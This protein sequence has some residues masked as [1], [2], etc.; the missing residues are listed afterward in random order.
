MKV[1]IFIVLSFFLLMNV[2]ANAQKKFNTKGEAQLRIEDTWSKVVAKNKVRQLAKINAIERVFGTYIEQETNIDI[3]DGEI[4]F[5]ILGNTRVKGEWLKTKDESFREDI[6]EVKSK[7]GKANEIWITCKIN[8]VVREIVRPKLAFVTNALNCQQAECRT[9]RFINGE[10]FYLHFKS[11][12]S[13]FLSVYIVEDDV[14]YRMLPY[15]EMI[16][17]YI[18]AVPVT[19]DKEYIFF[20][21]SEKHDYFEDFHFSRIDEI[22]METEDDKEYLKLYVVFS[23][24]K[25]SKPILKEGTVIIDGPIPK[26]LSAL[27]FEQWISQNRIYN[28]D[29]NY[30]ILNLEIVKQ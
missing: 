12:S 19:H 1:K 16:T 25:F 14:V 24:K 27:K 30:E 6:V 21:H 23:K 17:P 22:G 28:V 3:E 18:D 11:P 7:N 4:S 2:T 10:S 15:Q 5:K 26:S 8:G 20:S 29:F 13:G 9:T